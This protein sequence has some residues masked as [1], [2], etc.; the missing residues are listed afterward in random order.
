MK[1]QF[2]YLL[3]IALLLSASMQAQRWQNAIIVTSDGQNLEGEVNFE[4]YSLESLKIRDAYGKTKYEADDID[5]LIMDDSTIVVTRYRNAPINYGGKFHRDDK[6]SFFALVAEMGNTQLLAREVKDADMQSVGANT[7]IY[8]Y[9][10]EYGSPETYAFDFQ[11]PTIPNRRKSYSK[12][13][14][15]SIENMMGNSCPNLLE[16]MESYKNKNKF[17]THEQVLYDIQDICE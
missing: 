8:Y 6:K 13:N 5:Q 7:L 17:F 11:S 4:N 2:L 16:H 14:I 12:Q 3:V 15:K 10:S 1:I 9:L